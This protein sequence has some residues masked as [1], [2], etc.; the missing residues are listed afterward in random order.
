MYSCYMHC[1]TKT[2]LTEL[3]LAILAR[4]VS[5]RWSVLVQV[6][7]AARQGPPQPAREMEREGE[8]EGERVYVDE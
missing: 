1:I 6:C 8:R 2:L 5:A 3:H 4:L 7:A